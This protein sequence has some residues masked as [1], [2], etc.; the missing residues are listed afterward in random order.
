MRVTVHLPETEKKERLQRVRIGATGLA[1]VLL[2][3]LGAG[4]LTR[5]AS[6][7]T[8]VDQTPGVETPG[9]L[10]DLTGNA[11]ASQKTQEPLAEL[12]VAPSMDASSDPANAAQGPRP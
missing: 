7:E 5:S 6:D 12:G 1:A 10:P 2:V 11:G 8:P 3:I 4:A 9:G